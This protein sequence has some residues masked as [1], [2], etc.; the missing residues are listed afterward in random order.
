MDGYPDHEAYPYRTGHGRPLEPPTNNSTRNL[1][2]TTRSMGLRGPHPPS[3]GGTARARL[4]QR[5]RARPDHLEWAQARGLDAR[6]HLLG[7]TGREWYRSRVRHRSRL[8]HR[9]CWLKHEPRPLIKFRK[10]NQEHSRSC[11]ASGA[12]PAGP[13]ARP[14]GKTFATR[15]EECPISRL[16]RLREPDRYTRRRSGATVGDNPEGPPKYRGESYLKPVK[17]QNTK[18]TSSLTQDIHT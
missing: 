3:R 18:H 7:C 15:R 11:R 1:Q 6:L 14:R 2:S 5:R 17:T 9:R 10:K 4:K 8:K 12:R 16:Q 13:L